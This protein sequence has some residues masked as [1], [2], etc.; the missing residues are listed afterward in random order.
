[1]I[2]VKSTNVTPSE[3][4]AIFILPNNTPIE[5][6]RANNNAIWAT[7]SVLVNRLFNHSIVCYYY[8]YY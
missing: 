8:L 6:T 1:M 7:D 2:P 5:I 4:P 3:I